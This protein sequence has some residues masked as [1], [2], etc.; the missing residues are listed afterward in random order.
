[1][2]STYC[3]VFP[4]DIY[5]A[6]GTTM[7]HGTTMALSTTMALGT[8]ESLL[9]RYKQMSFKAEAFND[10]FAHIVGGFGNAVGY[11]EPI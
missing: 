6:L 7:A 5:L 4:T 10:V 9:V 11:K 8:I 2:P 3:R 1:M